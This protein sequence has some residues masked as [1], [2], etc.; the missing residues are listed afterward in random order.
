MGAWQVS[1]IL[2]AAAEAAASPK[3]G[4][5]VFAENEKKNVLGTDLIYST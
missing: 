5:A 1:R 4:L 2:P 3:T